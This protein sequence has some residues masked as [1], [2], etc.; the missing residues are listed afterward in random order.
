MTQAPT[1]QIHIAGL[2]DPSWSD[3]FD[4]LT[5]HHTADNMTILA[6]MFPDQAAL[7]GV[8]NKIRDLGLTLLTVRV[9][10][11]VSDNEGQADGGSE[12][13]QPD[14]GFER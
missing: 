12:T 9:E 5:I 14:Q 7:H 3:W 11:T 6:G 13:L 1:Y 10:M 8:L 4:G 2:L